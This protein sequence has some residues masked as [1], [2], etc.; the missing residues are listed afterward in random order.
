MNPPVS[1]AAIWGMMALLAGC[2]ALRD[3]ATAHVETAARADGQELSV[4]QLA[5]WFTT[6]RSLPVRADVVE[7][8]AHL[9]VD[10]VLFSERVAAGDS[11][12]DSVRVLAA[13][14]PEA[15][16][17]VVA[18]FH[19]RLV[20]ERVNLDSVRLDS[21][22]AA[23]DWRYLR[24]V[25]FRATPEMT[26]AQVAAKRRQADGIRGRLA[27]GGGWSQANALS[28]DSLARAAGGALGVVARG[29]TV[30][31]FEEAAY[32]LAPGELSQV[33]ESPFGFH[34][35]ERPRLADARDGFRAG[36][37]ER[38]VARLDSVFVSDLEQRRGLAL[39]GNAPG[40][41]RRA[42]SNPQLFRLSRQRLA[43]Y[44]G[45]H[46][47]AGDVLQWL[48]VLPPQVTEEI[49]T[50]SDDDLRRFLRSVVRDKLLY[51]EAAAAGVSLDPAD[52]QQLRDAVAT[53]VAAVRTALGLDSAAA[54]SATPVRARVDGYFGQ[55]VND[56]EKLVPVPRFLAD[57]LR[58]EG[59]ARVF[60]AGITRAYAIATAR[61][62]ALDSAAGRIPAVQP[63]GPLR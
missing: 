10:Y 22:Y 53:D 45:G 58:N 43:D 7:R 18:R 49:A 29:E 48:D 15:R 34:V 44:D 57:R 25:L 23:G 63:G 27:A 12:T 35:I 4:D 19:D 17:L 33:T 56:P 50:A 5:E 54:A 2:G 52:Y 62:A 8:V 28:E 3:A 42:A 46:V 1:G 32:R 14:W 37:L 39:R 40:L 51:T 61:R 21:V 31:A 36:V 26:Q 13:R 30:P 11:L 9:W 38:L 55:I 59:R 20:A 41:V 24:H 16:R 47:T 6:G 60:P